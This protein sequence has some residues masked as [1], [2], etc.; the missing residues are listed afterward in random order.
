MKTLFNLLKIFGVLIVVLFLVFFFGPK[1]SFEQFDAE[2]PEVSASLTELDQYLADKESKIPKIKPENESRIIWA[3]TIRQTEYALVYIH[4]FSAGVM[5]GA[6]LHQEVAKRY[7]MN[8]YLP[9]LSKHGIDDDDIFSE[10]TPKGLI[11]EAKEALVIGRKLGKKVILMGC[12]TGS[13]L[14]IYLMANH[15]EIEAHIGYSSNISLFDPMTKM[16]TG[17]W[18]LHL[19]KQLVGEYNLPKE[20]LNVPDSTL[21]KVRRYWSSKYRVEGMVALQGL[22]DMT[23]TEENFKK[24]DQPYFLGY[25]YKN[26]AL[27][28][29]TVSVEAIKKFDSMTATSDEM[30]RVVAFEEA[31]AHVINSPLISKEYEGVRDATYAYLEE[32]LGMDAKGYPN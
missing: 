10:L 18:G 29:M 16:L 12:S 24:I 27:Q 7:G 21:A 8:L 11:D 9:R 31:G 20:D 1:V 4:G 6:P 15:P 25:Y 19:V 26:E 17:P 32:V 13:T 28:D 14:A 3:D 23:M 22:I 2:L 5:E 30:K